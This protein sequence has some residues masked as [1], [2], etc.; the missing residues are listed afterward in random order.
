MGFIGDGSQLS[1]FFR[2]W[3]THD[4]DG[5][6]DPQY[7]GY[8][9]TSGNWYILKLTTT[10]IRYALPKNNDDVSYITA[11]TN[12]ATLNYGYIFE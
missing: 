4:L 11:W 10:S 3:F 1:P 8:T 2:E 7:Y 12:R 5:A 9:D 6:G